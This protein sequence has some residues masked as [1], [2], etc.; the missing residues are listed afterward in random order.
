MIHVAKISDNCWG[1]IQSWPN[2]DAKNRLEDQVRSAHESIDKA[3]EPVSWLQPN[4]EINYVGLLYVAQ[5][6]LDDLLQLIANKQRKSMILSV[7]KDLANMLDEI[8][9]DGELYVSMQQASEV[10]DAIYSVVGE[11]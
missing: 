9:P 5:Q 11:K 10:T 8:D 2:P 1:V 6:M 3:L 4:Q 7:M